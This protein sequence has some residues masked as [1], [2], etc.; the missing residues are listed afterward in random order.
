MNLFKQLCTGSL[1]GV[2]I[3]LVMLHVP[4]FH[5]PDSNDVKRIRFSD[6]RG[7]YR[8]I[9]RKVDCGSVGDF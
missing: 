1:I 8:L 6:E 3:G 7:F 4:V 5:G 9:P 2:L